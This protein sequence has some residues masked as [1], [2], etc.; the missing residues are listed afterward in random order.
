[1]E[2]CKKAF[3]NRAGK[4]TS[5]IEEPSRIVFKGDDGLYGC[6]QLGI[7]ALHGTK[8]FESCL[9]AWE[10]IDEE[11]PAENHCILESLSIQ[12]M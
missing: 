7:L 4:A 1:M 8:G 2:E 5:D 9:S 3:N 10:W 11:E 12:V 6:L